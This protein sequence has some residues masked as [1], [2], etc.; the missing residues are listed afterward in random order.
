M[1]EPEFDASDDP[2]VTDVESAVAST[3]LQRAA[4]QLQAALPPGWLVEI[5]TIPTEPV[6]FPKAVLRVVMSTG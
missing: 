4:G 3:P 1:T 6:G 5:A 2:G